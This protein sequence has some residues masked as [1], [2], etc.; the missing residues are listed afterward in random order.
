[1][2]PLPFKKVDAFLPELKAYLLNQKTSDQQ[3]FDELEGQIDEHFDMLQEQ[4]K[5]FEDL[6]QKYRYI[7]NYK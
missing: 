4:V 2:P 7:S 6:Q 5:A 3:Y 1:M